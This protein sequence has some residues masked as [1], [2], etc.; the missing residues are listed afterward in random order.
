[1]TATADSPGAVASATIVSFA[2]IAGPAHSD[3]G[4]AL[5]ITT[6]LK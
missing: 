5:R 1:V 4:V 3:F 6:R 2:T